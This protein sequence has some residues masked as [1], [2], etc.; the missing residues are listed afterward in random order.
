MA[1]S[2]VPHSPGRRAVPRTGESRGSTV[3][4]G[5]LQ[6]WAAWGSRGRGESAGVGGLG[7]KGGHTLPEQMRWV[8]QRGLRVKRF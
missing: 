7:E 2:I 6:A 8:D 4:R 3:G 5:R 1:F